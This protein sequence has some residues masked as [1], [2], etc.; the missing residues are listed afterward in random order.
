MPVP[1]P[2][3][4]PGQ[5][6]RVLLIALSREASYRYIPLDCDELNIVLASADGGIEVDD[7][8]YDRV[9]VAAFSDQ[10][11]TLR[12]V[13]D[14]AFDLINDDGQVLVCVDEA[15]EGTTSEQ[16]DE[17]FR[18][19]ETAG[20]GDEAFPAVRVV[21]S[22]DTLGGS[23][24]FL[25]GV[26]TALSAPQL[27]SAPTPVLAK[28][29][30]DETAP[31]DAKPSIK[32]SVGKPPPRSFKED[33]ASRRKLLL[34]AALG[35]LTA[36]IVSLV[37]VAFL[38]EYFLAIL[39]TAIALLLGAHAL[40]S[41]QQSRRILAAGRAQRRQVRSLSSK[42]RPE[43][44]S[45]NLDLHTTELAAMRRSI[46]INELTAVDNAKALYRID[47]GLRDATKPGLLRQINRVSRR[48]FEQVQATVNLFELVDVT[49]P[50]PP[51]RGWAVSPDALNIL[52][53]EF[54]ATRPR[55]VVECGSGVSTLWL[56]LVARKIGL[57]TRIVALDHDPGFAAKTNR[58]LEQHGVGVVASA[59]I[60]P[61]VDVT[62]GEATQPWYEPSAL[63]DLDD[64]GL[65]F[66]DGPPAATGP[67]ARYPALP[68]LW[69][70]L[71]PGASIV[72]DDT[73]RQDELDIIA[74]WTES[75]P[76]LSTE[77]FDTEKGTHILRRPGA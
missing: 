65:L 7:A 51:M 9:V 66:V 10:P 40:R 19:I 71:N 17:A 33:L 70:K 54:L 60:A 14:K 26:L 24:A 76:E 57:D 50:V 68:M 46:V 55:L 43:R 44:L 2:T 5:S 35:A 36:T 12:A 21:R 8:P 72:L 23:G 25:H 31:A 64:I 48:S 29:P 62:T 41:E 27:K 42:L 63:T 28:E 58:L 6:K 20:L 45:E 11:M 49:A 13:I 32:P 22:A 61:L 30:A 77:S 56:A 34:V 47:L 15:P 3:P 16:W 75:H 4:R 53:Q 39:G 74:Q 69:D 37:L 67:L 73:I 59:R 18:G 52:I 38:N 1:S